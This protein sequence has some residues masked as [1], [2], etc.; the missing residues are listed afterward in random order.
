MTY[1]LAV[2]GGIAT[3]KS[4]AD[5]F[6]ESKNIPIVDCDKIAHDLMKPKNAS[7]QA[8]RDAFGAEY[9][10]DD[11]TID[12]KKLGQLVFSD[13]TAL[14][15][16]NQLTHPLIFDKTIQKVK[17]HQNEGLVILDVPLYFESGWN[18]RNIANSVLVITL[19]EAIQIK[20]LMQRNGLTDQEAKM[21]IKSQ[22]PL[23]KK[24]Q[25]ADFVIENTGTIKELENKLEQ[26]LLK[27]K[28]EG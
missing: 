19:P 24:A 25:L 17:T 9:L 1:I 27:I 6:F 12:R 22:M 13:K 14:N 4:T 10:N 23:D 16:L 11:Q 20:R 18:N 26:L 8:I 15:K 21:R 3:G 2:T 28:E 5:Q 7:W